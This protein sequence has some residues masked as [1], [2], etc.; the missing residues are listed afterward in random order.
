MLLLG[1]PES[2]PQAE[3]LAAAAAMDYQAVQLHRFPD[4]ESQLTLPTDLPERVVVYRSLHHPNDKLIELYLLAGALRDAG[5]QQ[6]SLVAPYLCYMRQDIAF[7]PGEVVSQH[8]IGQLLAQCF[9]ALI[10]VDPHLHRTPTLQQAVPVK[11]AIT[12]HP[13]Q[14][15][16]E[17]LHRQ[18]AQV[19][20]GPDGESAQWVEAIARPYGLPHGVA[21]KERHGD[22][23]VSVHMPPLAVEGRPVVLVDDM[24]ST[25]HTLAQAARLLFEQGAASVDCA[26]THALLD[27][28]A[29][30]TLKAAGI[31]HL[32]STDAVPHSSNVIALT[33]LLAE[34]LAQ[35]EAAP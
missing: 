10:T 14:L 18:G 33:P 6:L 30:A 25:G 28:E 24:I 7:H 35:L 13:T 23:K 3:A 27:D 26:V 5:V 2:G 34:G 11:Q 19:L 31:R 17:F 21:S 12:L 8:Y 32:W 29:E 1:F 22:R 9:D 16:A 20:V 4:G 15:L